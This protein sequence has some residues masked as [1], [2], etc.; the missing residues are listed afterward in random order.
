M[1][2]DAQLSRRSVLIAGG[3]ALGLSCRR[4]SQTG[5]EPSAPTRLAPEASAALEAEIEALL[6]EHGVPGCAAGMVHGADTVWSAGFGM[7]DLE[8]DR[9]MS[10]DTLLNIGSVTKTVTATAVLQQVERGHLDLDSDVQ[11]WLGFDVRNPRHPRVPITT[12]QLLTHRSS[13]TDALPYE[14]SYAC[15]DPQ[16]PLG[17]WLADYF[18]AAELDS[19]FHLWPP[20]ELDPPEEPRAYSNVA[21][22]LLGHLVE[23]T[24]ELSYEDY[25]RRHI[26]TPLQM[27]SSGFDIARIDSGRHAVPYTV[28]SEDFEVQP[29]F[30]ES[31]LGRYPL[32]ERPP[33]PGEPYAH[34]LYSFAT[35]P[36]GL[37]RTSVNELARFL[38]CWINRG[39]LGQAQ[40]LRSDTVDLALSDR[41]FG[42]ALCWSRSSTLPGEPL[43]THSGG[44]P[45]IATLVGFRP[46]QRSGLIVL[47]N[48]SGPGPMFRQMVELLLETLDRRAREV[49]PTGAL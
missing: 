14:Q 5:D 38:L 39:S 33:V 3:T 44:D 17:Q 10:A 37:L 7:A 34:C 35:P 9:P 25:C 6:K 26:F 40:L 47:F 49:K 41:H 23:R 28:L 4:P 30:E 43:W 46:E 2:A 32:S 19:H 20:G 27:S 12:R 24:S 8:A 15:G 11:G 42:R 18:G 31:A 36:D 48:T 22:G 16:T 13:I 21:Y 45:G 1:K 29:D